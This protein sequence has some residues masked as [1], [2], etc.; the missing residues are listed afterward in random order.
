MNLFGSVSAKQYS[1]IGLEVSEGLVRMVQLVTANGTQQVHRMCQT[2][3][4][5]P[6]EDTE[7]HDQ[8]TAHMIKNLVKKH[9]FHGR[10]AVTGLSNRDVD[11]LPV[12]LQVKD[13]QDVEEKILENAK[14]RLHYDTEQA[15]IDYLPLEALQKTGEDQRVYWI[16]AARRQLV[17]RQLGILKQAGL[18]GRAIDIQPCALVRSVGFTEYSRDK[19][20]LVIHI[21]ERDTVFLL[22]DRGSLLAE[23]VCAKGYRDMAGKIQKTLD[24]DFQSAVGLLAD[25]GFAGCQEK[26]AA[27]PDST[28]SIVHEVILPVFQDVFD[29]LKS[30]IVYCYAEVKEVAI[31]TICLTGR[32]GDIKNLDSMIAMRTDTQTLVINPLETMGSS[33][34]GTSG[35]ALQRGAAFS[36]P[37]G[38]TLW[39]QSP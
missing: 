22:M 19:E 32:A 3:V 2:E 6:G 24:L 13:E 34:N 11:I 27:A 31:D 16:I 30:F 26:H 10:E 29:T 7:K 38:L 1:P 37:L 21:G 8:I 17:D 5:M 35:S 18:H 20:I 23:R 9:G 25:Y 15:V 36:V 33:A 28:G 14:A 39:E 12:Q 4:E